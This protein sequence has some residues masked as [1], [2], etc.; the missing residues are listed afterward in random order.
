ML[1]VVMGRIAGLMK[2]ASATQVSV[3][4]CWS[5][6]VVLAT[7]TDGLLCLLSAWLVSQ[8]IVLRRRLNV[9][10]EVFEVFDKVRA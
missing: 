5:V 7:E 6:F 4:Y 3:V 10:E 8:E 9:Q 2:M 1:S